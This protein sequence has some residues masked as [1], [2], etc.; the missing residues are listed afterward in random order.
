MI[1]SLEELKVRTVSCDRRFVG[2]NTS[3]QNLGLLRVLAAEPAT[4]SRLNCFKYS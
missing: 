4:P 2:A 3:E 1:E